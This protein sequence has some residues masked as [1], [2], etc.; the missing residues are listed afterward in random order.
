MTEKL[1]KVQTIS[2]YREEDELE[3]VPFILWMLA[4]MYVWIKSFLKKEE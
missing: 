1:W 4:A 3:G 2:T